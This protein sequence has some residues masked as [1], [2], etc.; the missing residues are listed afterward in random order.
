M[1]FNISTLLQRQSIYFSPLWFITKNHTRYQRWNQICCNR[2][3]SVF[4]HYWHK[5][6]CNFC[7]DYISW[8]THNTK[9]ELFFVH[10]MKYRSGNLCCFFTQALL[11]TE[12]LNRI[13]DIIDV[14]CMFT[15][16]LFTFIVCYSHWSNF[17]HRWFRQL[18]SVREKGWSV[19][20][21]SI[22]Q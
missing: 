3:Y 11:D 9:P 16:E 7:F 19:S 22:S 5:W 13:V 17:F 8:F 2:F 20:N 4:G 15:W 1:C 18:M 6:F 10:D 21:R 12:S 14:I